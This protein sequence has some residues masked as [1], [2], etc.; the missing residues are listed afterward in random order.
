MGNISSSALLD[1]ACTF[2]GSL[3]RDQLSMQVLSSGGM[4][5]PCT[6]SPLP[7]G[8]APSHPRGM[9]PPQGMQAKGTVLGLTP[10][11]RHPHHV[12]GRPG[13][14][15]Q[16]SGSRGR[17]SACPQTPLTTAK[18]TPPADALPPPLGRATTACKGA[19]CGANAGPPR[20]HQP[21]DT[22]VAEPRPTAPEDGRP[23]EGQR[24]KPDAPHDG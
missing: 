22:G 17:V 8:T 23:G 9:Q 24:L 20:P 5:S 13:Q 16:R 3:G 1:Y 14:P 12:G 19:R 21:R 11:Q 18:G 7:L 10:A 6:C 4:M 2:S 15:A